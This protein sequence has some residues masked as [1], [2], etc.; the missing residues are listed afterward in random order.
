[1]IPDIARTALWETKAA[2]WNENDSERF[3]VQETGETDRTEQS[4]ETLDKVRD[5]LEEF[6]SNVRS[7]G[8]PETGGPEALEATAVLEGIVESSTTGK[9]VDLDEVRSRE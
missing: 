4:I 6:V 2:A 1:M 9:I 5:E 3:F 7:G 8:T